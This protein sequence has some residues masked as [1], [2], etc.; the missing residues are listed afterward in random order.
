V[1]RV[2]PR[3]VARKRLQVALPAAG[4]AAHGAH[5]PEAGTHAARRLLPFA[6]P[7]A[8]GVHRLQLHG[9]RLHKLG[10]L[11]GE[12]RAKG[13]VELGAG[14]AGEGRHDEG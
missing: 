2:E 13:G 12:L 1:R 5:E 8:H 10:A 6:H 11:L 3:R 9:G 14:G 7:A 4:L